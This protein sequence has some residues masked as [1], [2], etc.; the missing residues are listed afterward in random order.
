M[1][2]AS[3]QHVVE[4]VAYV[5]PGPVAVNTLSVNDDQATVSVDFDV[6]KES[7]EPLS[8]ECIVDILYN[9]DK[10]LEKEQEIELSDTTALSIQFTISNPVLTNRYSELDEEADNEPGPDYW[11]K[12]TLK[13][14]HKTYD[15]LM[16]PFALTVRDFISASEPRH[17]R[18]PGRWHQQRGKQIDSLTILDFQYIETGA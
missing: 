17:D 18:M 4:G 6:I 11:A 14:G 2:L 12:I 5:D 8:V 1:G 7:A 3:C 10:I 16:L 15:T 9:D 13:S